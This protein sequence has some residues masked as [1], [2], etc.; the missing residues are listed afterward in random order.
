MVWNEL[1]WRKTPIPILVDF[2]AQL[3]TK[4]LERP[5][6]GISLI[7]FDIFWYDS[8]R[9]LV[10]RKTSSYKVRF[11]SSSWISVKQHFNGGWMFTLKWWTPQTPREKWKKNPNHEKPWITRLIPFPPITI[12]MT[13]INETLRNNSHWLCFGGIL[14]EPFLSWGRPW[15]NGSLSEFHSILIGQENWRGI[16]WRFQKILTR[17]KKQT[18]NNCRARSEKIGNRNV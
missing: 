8:K 6:L 16:F 17:K 3:P 10:L 1:H 9:F 2:F 13:K 18:S 7:R 4:M 11:W 12:L 5:R 14:G 15:T